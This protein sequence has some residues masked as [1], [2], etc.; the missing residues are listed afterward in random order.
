VFGIPGQEN[1]IWTAYKN[2]LLSGL[3]AGRKG[4]Q[5]SERVDLRRVQEGRS[6]DQGGEDSGLL[7]LGEVYRQLG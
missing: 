4:I 1:D 3:Q 6:T 5:E 7:R 2:R